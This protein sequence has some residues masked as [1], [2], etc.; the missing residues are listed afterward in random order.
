MARYLPEKV[1]DGSVPPWHYYPAAEAMTTQVG[2][3]MELEAGELSISEA[4]TAPEPGAYICMA[5]NTVAVAAGDLIPVI[6]VTDETILEEVVEEE[7]D[8]DIDDGGEG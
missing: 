4:E 7:S 3:V 1:L 6:F 2:D 5:E 8:E